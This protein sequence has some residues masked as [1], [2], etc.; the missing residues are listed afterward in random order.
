MKSFQDIWEKLRQQGKHLTK[1]PYDFVVSF[2]FRYYPKEKPRSK[3][4]ILDVGC[5]IGNHL[6]FLAKEGFNAFG[7]DGSETAVKLAKKLLKEF[8][9]EADIK[10]HDFTKPLPYE[11]NFFDLVIDR[12]SLSCIDYSE[13]QKTLEEIHRVLKTGG[14]FL[15]SPYSKSHTSYLTSDKKGNFVEV[16]EGSLKGTGWVCFYDEKDIRKLFSSEKWEL[17]ELSENISHDKISGNVNSWW[18][19]VAKKKG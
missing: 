18:I 10:V 16:V 9:V 8:N 7:I 19:V 2:V 1:Y 17:I 11:N 6:W 13:M 15:F 3:I 14:Y 5:G 4:N 12:S